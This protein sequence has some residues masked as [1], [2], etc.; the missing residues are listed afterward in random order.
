MFATSCLL[1][2]TLYASFAQLRQIQLD[3]NRPIISFTFRDKAKGYLLFQGGVGITTDT[4]HTYQYKPFPASYSLGKFTGAD[5]SN[6]FT[7]LG[8]SSQ[9][10]DTIL[11]VGSYP[12]A[13]GMIMSADNGNTY[14]LVY[15]KENMGKPYR[16]STFTVP[17]FVPKSDTGY[18]VDHS[19][20]YRTTDRGANWEY[21]QQTIYSQVLLTNISSKE[22]WQYIGRDVYYYLYTYYRSGIINSPLRG[23]P[24]SFYFSSKD[25]AWINTVS[26]SGKALILYSTNAG[27]VWEVLADGT[28]DEY[29]FSQMQFADAKTGFAT[30]EDYNLWRTLD[31]G[32]TWHRLQHASPLPSTGTHKA[33]KVFDTQQVIAGSNSGLA[34]ITSN[35]GGKGLPGVYFNPDTTGEYTSNIIHL[36]NAS[37][38]TY[39]MAWYLNG[40]PISTNYNTTYTRDYH[41]L[42]DTLMLVAET[43]AGT[44]DSLI[45]Y[46]TFKP[47]VIIT[48]L[49][50]M[51]GIDNTGLILTGEN[52][53]QA[54]AVTIGGKSVLFTVKSP[55]QI[56]AN[57][58]MTPSGTVTVYTPNG[59]ASYYGFTYL[60]PPKVNLPVTFSKPLLC[61]AEPLTVTVTNAE[62]GIR[63]ELFEPGGATVGS[64]L[65]TDS[66]LSFTTRTLTQRGNYTMKA[67]TEV[68]PG[69]IATFTTTYNIQIEY[70]RA[71]FETD[72]V[73]ITSGEQV[74]FLSKA[75]ESTSSSFVFHNE[76]NNRFNGSA[77]PV[78]FNSA[79]EKTIDL[80]VSS[81]TGCADTLLGQKITVYD[82]A[83]GEDVCYASPLHAVGSPFTNFDVTPCA[84]NGYLLIGKGVDTTV[85]LSRYGVNKTLPGKSTSYMAKYKPDGT[86][87]WISYLL[88]EGTITSTATDNDGNIYMYGMTKPSVKLVTGTGDTLTLN[89][90]FSFNFNYDYY[91]GF[92]VKMSS[93]GK[94]IWQISL[95][96]TNANS[97]RNSVKTNGIAV[98]N[99][100]IT[101]LGDFFGPLSIKD[102]T[103]S[104]RELIKQPATNSVFPF[105]SYVINMTLDGNVSWTT[106]LFNSYTNSASMKAF[107]SDDAGNTYV[108][109]YMEFESRVVDAS[110]KEFSYR[111][112]T[113]AGRFAAFVFKLD[114]N[115]MFKWRTFLESQG[116]GYGTSFIYQLTTDKAGNCYVNGDVSTQF[117]DYKLYTTH[118]NGD[119]TPLPDSLN[120]F[121]TMKLTT[122]GRVAWINGIKWGMGTTATG[123]AGPIDLNGAT[124]T[125]LVSGF[126]GKNAT[127]IADGKGGWWS[128]NS[129]NTDNIFLQFD[130]SGVLKKMIPGTSNTF[131]TS[132][133]NS[134]KHDASGNWLMTGLS[135]GYY[136]APSTVNILNNILPSPSSFFLKAKPDFCLDGVPPVADAGPDKLICSGDNVTLGTA[137]ITGNRYYWTSLLAGFTAKT[138]TISVMPTDT[139][140]YIL[141]VTGNDGRR[142]TDS[143]KV[144]IKGNRK[145][146]GVNQQICETTS[147]RIGTAAQPGATYTWTSIPAGFSSTTANPLVSPTTSTRYIVTVTNTLECQNATT[148]TVLVKLI[149]KVVPAVRIS[150]YDSLICANN[151]FKMVASGENAGDTPSYTWWFNGRAAIPGIAK[152]YLFLIWYQWS[153]KGECHLKK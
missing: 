116:N 72:K 86:L 145:P 18:L 126:S 77:I 63:Y 100:K 87:S 48:K 13:Y 65:A 43:P 15:Y 141:T 136:Q 101:I 137:A 69:N 47:R 3:K 50:S 57:V 105:Y 4:A 153:G 11:V 56:T 49:S 91:C 36:R 58:Y 9:H 103:G 31:G 132:G 127:A 79:G 118:Q 39:R 150:E 16:D 149:P 33:L 5:T 25:S 67:Y 37:D 90:G 42:K 84:D 64:G 140:I 139:T 23:K 29:R 59:I 24:L 12:K 83:D 22:E 130:T 119:T 151:N 93:T 6:R 106:S 112:E 89:T 92:V 96:D 95:F 19:T 102:R 26:D 147:T 115:G 111:K 60:K 45:R 46:L 125:S 66:V 129:V 40:K 44:K 32:R 117:N 144:S 70:P 7:P 107:S 128:L 94:S 34:E 73:N 30:G 138:A 146:A 8:I 143:V 121:F 53:D 110:G 135:K 76:I 75:Q 41:K 123:S 28:N 142:S 71:R 54:Y 55:T 35:G 122:D 152:H 21:Q 109:G 97:S 80:Y 10:G 81:A 114:A 17:M 2:I 120:G 78:T 20:F 131:N 61:K 133:F 113:R 88:G 85:V 104:V 74:V 62:P 1:L 108:A 148:D 68:F 52:L 134:L 14:T 98:R 51:Y 82:A 124:L 27:K 38:S 99:N